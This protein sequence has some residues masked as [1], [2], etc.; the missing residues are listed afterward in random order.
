[1]NESS[2]L[3]PS[4]NAY[5]TN[6]TDP[7]FIIRN[8]PNYCQEHK[9]IIESYCCLKNA[10]WHKD[11]EWIKTH[12]KEGKITKAILFHLLYQNEECSL[13]CAESLLE[14]I[15]PDTKESLQYKIAHG[16]NYLED[17]E[18]EIIQKTKMTIDHLI[19]QALNYIEEQEVIK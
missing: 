18:S 1:M 11:L 7:S 3:P 6:I 17:S 5:I 8:N 14:A 12:I 4:W 15:I 16:P 2:A 13:D 10:S 19:K 9:N